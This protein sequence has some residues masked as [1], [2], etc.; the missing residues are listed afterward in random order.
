MRLKWSMSIMI[1]VSAPR[2]AQRSRALLGKFE[3]DAPVMQ[4][5][6]RI[7]RRKPH[8][9]ALHRAEPLGGAQPRIKFVR[10]RRL[11][12]E[13]VGAGIER[14]AELALVDA[15]RHQDHV[16]RPVA[17]G[18]HARLPAQLQAR[19]SSPSSPEVISAPTSISARMQASA[20]APSANGITS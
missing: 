17:P 11:G 2:S 10:D 3:E 13:I 5:G 9:F 18:E 6:E 20:S 7:D 19:T 15:R 12:D 1:A 4:T 14:L 16:D 8:Q